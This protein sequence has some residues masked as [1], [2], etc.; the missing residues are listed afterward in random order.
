MALMSFGWES[1]CNNWFAVDGEECCWF[2]LSTLIA[3]RYMQCFVVPAVF[4][5]R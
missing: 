1:Q 4:N 3:A 5:L 2:L